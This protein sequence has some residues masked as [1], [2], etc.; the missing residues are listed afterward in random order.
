MELVNH[1]HRTK[2]GNFHDAVGVSKLYLPWEVMD[3]MP[4]GDIQY[5]GK[6]GSADIPRLKRH[7]EWGMRHKVWFIGMGDIVDFL[8]PS[9]RTKLAV[10]GIYDTAQMVID[11]AAEE[12]ENEIYEI[13][14]PTIGHW[15]GN[16]QGH[17]YFE[18]L[19]GST[20]DTR[21]AEMFKC[22][23]L[24]D[25]AL[26][27]FR[28]REEGKGHRSKTLKMW[29]HHGTGGSGVTGTAVLNRMYHQKVRYPNVRLFLHGHVPVLAQLVLDGLD[30]TDSATPHLTHEDTHLVAT[31]GF[32]RSY[33]QG[34][35]FKGRAQG[36]YAEKAMY[37]PATLGGA[38][39]HLTP[40]RSGGGGVDH[41]TIDIKVTL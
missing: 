9:N 38:L 32:A 31:G 40:E 2:D 30:M 29:A 13:L 39:I 16:L 26:V 18:H 33:Q 34:S 24:G 5:D 14:K 22:P 20:S 12:L 4:I 1:T 28:F 19:D 7:V 36:G 15:I 41:T 37:P 25:C 35:S 17:H 23:F 11:H 6:R 8:S 3:I 10:S 21:F 27:A